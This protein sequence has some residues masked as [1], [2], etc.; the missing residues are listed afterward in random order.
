MLDKPDSAWYRAE[1]RQMPA[2]GRAMDDVMLGRGTVIGRAHGDIVE[3]VEVR[4][5]VIA[6]GD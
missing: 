3:D 1:E 4:H 2:V 6:H 5:S